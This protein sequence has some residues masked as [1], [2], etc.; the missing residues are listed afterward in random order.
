MINSI[1][2]VLTSRIGTDSIN[3][4]ARKMAVEIDVIKQD[5][6]RDLAAGRTNLPFDQYMVDSWILSNNGSKAAEF[7]T[8]YAAGKYSLG[9]VA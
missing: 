1:Q 7:R 2:L 9:V 6:Q 3:S 8:N 5:Y 4:L